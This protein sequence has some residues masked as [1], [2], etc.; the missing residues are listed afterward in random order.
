MN[1]DLFQLV[2][3]WAAHK[4]ILGTATPKDQFVKMVEEVGEVA[5]CL[6]KGN[7]EAIKL[8]I[9]DVMVTAILMAELHGYS[10]EECLAAAYNKI[11]K[12]QGKMVEGVFVKDE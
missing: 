3:D 12:R 7:R 8:E 2:A 6:A 11:V 10:G 4:G 9:G 1:G 5:E